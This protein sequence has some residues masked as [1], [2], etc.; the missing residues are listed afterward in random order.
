MIE[1]EK[2]RIANQKAKEETKK[3]KEDFISNAETEQPKTTRRKARASKSGDEG[4]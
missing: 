2:E 4:R 3:Q 1:T